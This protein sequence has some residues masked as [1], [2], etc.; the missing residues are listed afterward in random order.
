VIGAGHANV[1]STATGS[2]EWAYML[3]QYVG[4]RTKSGEM[5]VHDIQTERNGSTSGYKSHMENFYPKVAPRW[6]PNGNVPVVIQS[7]EEATGI[8]EVVPV[9][10]DPWYRIWVD[11]LNVEVQK[12]LKGIVTSD[13]CCDTLIKGVEDAKKRV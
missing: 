11:M 8:T 7:Y 13:Q 3:L 1:V 5:V 10:L 9:I 2:K 6:V 12:C 4:G